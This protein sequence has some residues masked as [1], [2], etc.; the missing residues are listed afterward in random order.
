MNWW[1]HDKVEQFMR[2]AGFTKVRRSG[3]K[4]S[5]CAVMRGE[6]FD[7]THWAFSLYMEAER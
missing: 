3:H 6:Q 2:R 4:Q 7:T 5:L 1:T